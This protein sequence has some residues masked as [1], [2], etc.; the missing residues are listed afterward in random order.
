M[1]KF[2]FLSAV[3]AVAAASLAALA[4]DE[5]THTLVHAASGGGAHAAHTRHGATE[6]IA[7]RASGL[8]TDLTDG[9]EATVEGRIQTSEKSAI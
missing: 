3:L 9:L 6:D 4:T 5:L 2:R 8:L 1:K 7:H